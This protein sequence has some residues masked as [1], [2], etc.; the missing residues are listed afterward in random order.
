MN[1]ISILIIVF[2]IILMNGIACAELEYDW[3][4]ERRNIAAENISYVYYDFEEGSNCAPFKNQY[5]DV[6]S[7]LTV[8]GTQPYGS[9]EP[10]YVRYAGTTCG[11]TRC[12]MFIYPSPN[13]YYNNTP[14]PWIYIVNGKCA[15][16]PIT[17]SDTMGGYWP[18]TCAR[19]Q[20]NEGT[21]YISF[22]SS[23]G[24]N[25]Y[26]RLYDMQGNQYNQV[27]YEKIE[28]NYDRIGLN[29]SN[30]TR[31]EFNIPN[32]DINRMDLHGSFNG[33]H[34]DDLIIGVNSDYF[35]DQPVD[36]T[37]VA[38]RAQELHGVQY[39]EYGFGYD[40]VV[41]DYMDAWQFSDEMIGEYWNPETK[42]FN[43]G[44]GIS[45]AGLILW[46]YN[47]DSIE[48]ADQRFVKWDTAANMEK[49]DFKTDVDPADTIPG[50][51]AFKDRDYDGYADEVYMVIEET[52]TGMDIIT[53]CPN[54]GV[55]YSTS[56]ILESSPAFMG[57][58]RLPGVIKGGHNPIPKGH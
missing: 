2:I 25:L 34:I 51:V 54:D 57:Y 24:G 40:Y 43:E 9:D 8:L 46:A 39:L 11:N 17:G 30:F 42:E 50:D 37:Y 7:F 19:I 12:K 21:N 32:S 5:P 44:E 18:G 23:T 27:H 36:Y 6:T 26:I 31:F 52:P 10:S 49:H 22:L 15:F 33:W 13:L 55:I 1:K 29:P 58:K 56:S 16:T 3:I 20:F 38:R 45:N 14:K 47:Y 28:S 41:L 4:H 35:P 48:L 53:S